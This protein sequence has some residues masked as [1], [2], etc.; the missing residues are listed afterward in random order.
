MKSSSSPRRHQP[1]ANGST[2]RTWQDGA[3]GY[4]ARRDVPTVGFNELLRDGLPTASGM[5]VGVGEDPDT[6][7][8]GCVNLCVDG[9]S[10]V[11]EAFLGPDVEISRD[12]VAGEEF[13]YCVVVVLAFDE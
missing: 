8:V 13:V 5:V 3:T 4:R 12:I 2:A 6:A 9:L 1:Y 11:L 10:Q 7:A